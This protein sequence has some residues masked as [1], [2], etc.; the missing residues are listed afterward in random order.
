MKMRFLRCSSLTHAIQ[1]VF[2]L[3]MFYRCGKEAPITLDLPEVKDNIVSSLM[4]KIEKG[5]PF[6]K[7]KVINHASISFETLS[8]EGDDSAIRHELHEL[9]ELQELKEEFSES[10]SQEV[11]QRS[12][13]REKSLN[14]IFKR[15]KGRPIR[16]EDRIQEG[17]ENHYFLTDWKD[18]DF[19]NFK[20]AL[21]G[22]RDL[23][24]E[25]TGMAVFKVIFELF[26]LQTEE[27]QEGMRD[28]KDLEYNL[29]FYNDAYKEKKVF[30]DSAQFH[31]EEK[32]ESIYENIEKTSLISV[33]Q[34]NSN[35]FFN[36][37]MKRS[38]II[39]QVKDFSFKDSRGN[40]IKYSDLYENTIKRMS[41]IVVSTPLDTVVYFIKPQGTIL[42]FLN[43]TP[44]P[45]AIGPSG[46]IL[47]AFDFEN[48]KKSIWYLNVEAV[49]KKLEPE[50]TYVILYASSK[51]I[52]SLQKKSE[53]IFENVILEGSVS[54]SSI[55]FGDI[56]TFDLRGYYNELDYEEMSTKRLL[57]TT[58]RN[59]IFGLSTHPITFSHNL[60]NLKIKLEIDGE[61]Y[62][63]DSSPPPGEKYVLLEDNR[64]LVLRF[65]VNRKVGD[66][67]GQVLVK[68]KEYLDA[69]YV[70]EG[71]VFEFICGDEVDP[72]PYKNKR[73]S[74]FDSYHLS[75]FLL[76][77]FDYD[78]Q[79]VQHR[80]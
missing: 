26:G 54:I 65:V 42:D 66:I 17:D 48:T 4:F 1:V 58:K 75:L 44:S 67:N 23:L 72:I 10:R 64:R 21:E 34:L 50:K 76:R 22:K 8:L 41:R 2:Y 51:E 33:D 29:S 5:H 40:W 43:G 55:K 18:T 71:G 12:Y 30:F 39:L 28:I 60:K 46:N 63:L 74:K 70:E 9:H 7:V 25:D 56:L 47:S 52:G 80:Y 37:L 79:S 11:L 69:E 6:L 61:E 36:E 16:E 73:R 32:G 57:C 45:V 15:A 20:S 53:T 78:H 68:L 27:G 19:F 31:Y 77:H 49:K 3:F 24:K 62:D 35:L 13:L 59:E 14:L 38:E